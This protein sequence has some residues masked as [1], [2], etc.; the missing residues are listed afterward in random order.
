MS[1]RTMT[2]SGSS[3]PFFPRILVHFYLIWHKNALYKFHLKL[4]LVYLVISIEINGFEFFKKEFQFLKEDLLPFTNLI[5]A[6]E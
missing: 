3:I 2:N 6:S 1:I 4:S 5:K